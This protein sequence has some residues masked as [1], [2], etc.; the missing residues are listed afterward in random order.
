MRAVNIWRKVYIIAF[1][2]YI[3]LMPTVAQD[4][5][6][7][8]ASGNVSP[9]VPDRVDVQPV[10]RDEEIETRLQ[11]ILIATG[12]FIDPRVDVQDG[13]VFLTGQTQTNE[14]KDWAGNLARNTQDVCR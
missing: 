14:F 9:D 4:A 6:P 12:W 8:P 11:D 1:M 5:T 2:L 7:T 13:V 10:A 3:T